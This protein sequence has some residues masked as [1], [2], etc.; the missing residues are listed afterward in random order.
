MPLN[1]KLKIVTTSWDDG[2]AR[3]LRIAELLAARG[4][5]GT[6]YCPIKPFDGNPALTTAQQRDMVADGFEIGAHTIN[7]EI[8]SEVPVEQLEYIVGTCKNMLEDSLGE[9]IGMFCYPRGRY[10]G[11]V[12]K[13]LK[14]AR[15][16][17]A[18][19]VRLLATDTNYGLYDLPTSIQVYPHTRSEYLRN[20]A[21]S[22]KANRLIDYLTRLGMDDDWVAIGKKLF[23]R[24]LER[25]G[26]WHLWG[27]SW[28]VD[29]LGQWDSLREML[30]YVSNQPDVLYLNNG[31]MVKSLQ[32]HSAN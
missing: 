4:L 21:R 10:T 15:Y 26:V 3:D 8:L 6:F 18:R 16:D 20:I 25:G 12:V 9:R 30:D 31:Q 28:E 22:G 23:D 1:S 32:Q 27:H 24:V 5:R 2:D 7:H 14:K 29:G 11:N 19:T 13:A 17:G